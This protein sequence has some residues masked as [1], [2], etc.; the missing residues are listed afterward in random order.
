MNPDAFA[1]HHLPNLPGNRF[2]GHQ[3]ISDQVGQGEL[4]VVCRELETTLVRNIPGDIAEFGCYAGTT[5]LFIRRIL[6]QQAASA[7][8]TFHV[9]DSFE[10]LPAKSPQDRS[11]GGVDFAAGKLQ[12]SKKEFLRQFSAARLK[13]PMVHKGWFN[14][15][16]AKDIP[17]QLAFAFLDGDFYHSILVSLQL[18]WPRLATG[19]VV[20]I[21]DYQNPALPGVERAVHAFFGRTPSGLQVEANVAI[22]RRLSQVR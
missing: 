22:I 13:P 14:D 8:R 15:L 17:A 21:D 5:S 16:T 2:R 6:D 18:V 9:Y 7:K 3:I 11:A 12:V 19:G 1:F 4:A 10:G 20:L